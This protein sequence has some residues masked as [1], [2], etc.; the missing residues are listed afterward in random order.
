MQSNE[1]SCTDIKSSQSISEGMYEVLEPTS[2]VAHEI[3]S[4]LAS[5]T[6]NLPLTMTETEKKTVDTALKRN[7]EK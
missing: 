6:A 4:I 3:R 7:T 1:L 5:R 2:A